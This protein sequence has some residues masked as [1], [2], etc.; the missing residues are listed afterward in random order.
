MS[1]THISQ[2]DNGFD[3]LKTIIKS[4]DILDILQQVKRTQ[5][6]LLDDDIKSL[7]YFEKYDKLA[8]EFN[9]FS[10]SYTQ[11]FTMV[12]KEDKDALKL[13]A[14]ALYYRDK[15]NRGLLTESQLTDK[16]MDYYFTDDMKIKAKE[17]IKKMNDVQ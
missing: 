12:V 15:C 11:I 3:K 4:P 14:S 17:G 7:G 13:L 8:R 2:M 9:E 10:D 5:L 1:L 16:L 6:R